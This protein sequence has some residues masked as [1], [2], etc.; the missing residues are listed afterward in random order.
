M[1]GAMPDVR[2]GWLVLGVWVVTAA[3]SAVTQR[4][5][6]EISPDGWTYWAASISLLEGRGYVDGH[7]LPVEAWPP[8]Y[9][10]WLACVQA[11]IGVSAN[12]VRI[13]DAIALGGAAAMVFLWGVLRVGHG[14]ARWPMA[15]VATASCLAAARGMG[16]EKPML[17][18]LFAAMCCVETSRRATGWRFAAA[19]LGMG[20]CCIAAVLTRHAALA[21]LPGMWFLLAGTSPATGCRRRA[22]VFAILVLACGGAWLLVR[23]LLEQHSENWWSRSQSLLDLLRAMTLG[24]DRGLGPFPVGI[25]LFVAACLAFGAMRQRV[26]SWL[27]LPSEKLAHGDA[28]RFLLLSLAALLTQFLIVYVN[29]PPGPRFVRFAS[30][31]TCV[32]L[33]AVAT[34]TPRRGVRWCLLALLLL[35]NVVYAG[36]HLLRGR[37]GRSDVTEMGGASFVPLRAIPET[38]SR[39]PDLGR[40]GKVSVRVPLFRWQRLRLE[41]GEGR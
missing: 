25:I 33:T 40:Q 19:V 6:M 23:Q 39:E 10:L 1:R 38:A 31:T 16:S 20:C 24:I 8:G 13:A 2:T 35:P 34:Q 7:G 5:G 15:V 29:D 30:I 37:A 32:L 36:K 11:V 9:S 28:V 22:E 4:H 41:N 18:F 17:W 26:A 27:A 3:L 21:F 12:A 14:V